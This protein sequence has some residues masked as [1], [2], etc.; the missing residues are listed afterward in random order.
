M[1]GQNSDSENKLNLILLSFSFIIVVLMLFA[2]S[3]LTESFYLT[4]N[5]LDPTFSYLLYNALEI[6]AVVLVFILFRHLFHSKNDFSAVTKP[7]L[8]KKNISL[9]IIIFL[10]FYGL[11]GLIN[12]LLSTFFGFPTWQNGRLNQSGINSSSDPINALFYILI[13]GSITAPIV[14]EIQFRFLTD[15]F[16]PDTFIKK[17]SFSDQHQ[18]H[19]NLLKKYIPI[20]I[21]FPLYHIVDFA[22]INGH[23]DLVL[24]FNLETPI[25]IEIF[26]A[27]IVFIILYKI[28]NSI[29]Y[30]ILIHFMN[31]TLQLL[32]EALDIL[33]LKN[34]ILVAN[35]DF[36]ISCLFLV[37][38]ILLVYK[39]YSIIILKEKFS[40]I[41]YFD[42]IL[43]IVGFTL[44]YI[45]FLWFLAIFLHLI[46]LN[47]TLITFLLFTFLIIYVFS[48]KIIFKEKSNETTS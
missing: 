35:I 30:T 45:I 44:L 16:L 17:F 23:N 40:S 1:E 48:H 36:S 38:G 14:E 41:L 39:K 32:L 7:S 12:F 29:F 19:R 37:I 6:T 5:S 21:A 11:V 25:L 43:I 15:N 47:L 26:S 42:Y 20:I 27:S 28:T 2:K 18:L 4:Q 13:I 22:Y 3:I 9:T 31:N 10:F 34:S 24:N 8:F 33:V 46:N